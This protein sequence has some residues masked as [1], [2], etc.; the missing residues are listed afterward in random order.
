[1]KDVIIESERLVLK[2]PLNII[3]A[4]QLLKTINH[5]ETLQYLAAAPKNY[6]IDSAK[7]FL[8][9]LN[10]KIESP[11]SLEL[12]A[13]IKSNNEYIGMITLVNI[14]MNEHV[15]ELGYWISKPFT[16]KGLAIEGCQ[17]LIQYAFND[18]KI[19]RIDAFVIRENMKSISLLERLG[20]K[21]IE[22]LIN[23]TEN[24]GVLVD[25]Y[26]YSLEKQR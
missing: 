16:G 10:K 21:Q 12:G 24:D 15:C 11:N 8:S 23:N 9:Y 13:F 18:L 3:N 4:E 19:K 14:N 17:K 22:L 6:T 25:R 26:K 5:T 1:M 2:S 20:F 7:R